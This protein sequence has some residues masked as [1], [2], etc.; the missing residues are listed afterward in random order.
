MPHLLIALLL[1]LL[2]LA[3]CQSSKVTVDYDSQTNFN[4]YRFYQ[5]LPEKSG[6]SKDFDP[7]MSERIK[8]ALE[9]QLPNTGMKLAQGGQATD[10]LVRYYMATNT[11][12]S[13]S[14]GSV[15][16]GGAS[17]GGSSM[18]GVSL[19]MPL[20]GDSVT[21]ETQIM[22]DFIDAGDEK[23]KWRG[24]R[25][26]KFSDEPPEQLTKMVQEVVAEILAKYPPGK[27]TK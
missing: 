26:L 23:L 20:G 3:G 18:M 9:Q 7:L 24:T 5:W 16:V 6:S 12:S 25:T 13:S 10:V 8:E 27:K 19:S 1:P 17:G 2:I 15:G 4:N 14:K 22:I 21:R 11:K